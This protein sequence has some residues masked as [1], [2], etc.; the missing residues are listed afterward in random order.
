MRVDAAVFAKRATD[1]LSHMTGTVEERAAMLK[2]V[3]AI[4]DPVAKAAALK[5]LHTA[6]TLA[7]SAFAK[8]G[9][10]GGPIGG[11]D[12]LEKINNLAKDYQ[13]NNPKVTFAKA[14]EAVC[15]ENP[16]LYEKAEQERRER[17]A[18]VHSH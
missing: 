15:E 1:E 10:G 18:A 7:K 3:E 13:K 11:G 9:M 16:G 12:T 17:A 14:Y 5:G 6:N 8:V 4:S 2:G